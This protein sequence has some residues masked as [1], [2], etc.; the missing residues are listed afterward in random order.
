MLNYRTKKVRQQ[1]KN[2]ENPTTPPLYAD[3]AVDE[4][5]SLEDGL[6]HMA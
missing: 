6:Y 4:H 1:K 3:I 2:R 5:T